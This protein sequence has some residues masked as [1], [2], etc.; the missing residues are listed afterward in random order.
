M[1]VARQA[2]R[3]VSER[4][5]PL[6]FERRVADLA[7]VIERD[8]GA[9]ITIDAVR[10][11]LTATPDTTSRGS[12]SPGVLLLYGPML[13][14]AASTV[15]DQLETRIS[16]VGKELIQDPALATA[17]ERASG[18]LRDV[19]LFREHDQAV[20][21][22][23]DLIN[24]RGRCQLTVVVFDWLFLRLR[25]VPLPANIRVV[26]AYE[27]FAPSAA[28]LARSVVWDHPA[29]ADDSPVAD[30]LRRCEALPALHGPAGAPV[31]L[32]APAL[33]VLADLNAA[34]RAWLAGRSLVTMD[35]RAL[36][37]FPG[38]RHL[39]EF[40]GPSSEIQGEK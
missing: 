32:S 18:L 37:R 29:D 10:D 30:A 23:A 35:A 25:E 22:V 40:L 27:V 2:H 8:A 26:P 5:N 17:L 20:A 38:A 7:D 12:S 31:L 3:S 21:E 19:G 6:A 28:A 11:L 1:A 24:A 15:V 33:R 36:V 14:R 13:R 39:T 16:T 34:K 4:L 9:R